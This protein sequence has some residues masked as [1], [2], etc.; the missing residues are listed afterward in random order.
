MRYA[1]EPLTTP[2]RALSKSFEDNLKHLLLQPP[3][4]GK[5]VLG[6]DPGYAHGCKLAVVDSTGRVLDTAVIYPMKPQ[7][8]TE[9][10]SR[11]IKR[12]VSKYGVNV[13]AIGNGTASKESEIFIAGADQ[14]A[15]SGRK[16]CQ[17]RGSQRGWRVGLFGV[18]AC[19]GGIP[20]FRRYA[21]KRRLDRKTNSGPSGGVVK[22]DPEVD[23][24][25]VSISMI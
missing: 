12:L 5:V 2:A 10:A 6:Y 3:L 18:E 9:E 11:I 20:G 1:P 19:G 22:I 17:V 4:K 23:R 25:S 24:R 21:E 8:R 16:D 7:S 13:I 15:V 14:R